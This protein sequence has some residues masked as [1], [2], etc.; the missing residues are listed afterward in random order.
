MNQSLHALGGT[1]A[2]IVRDCTDTSPD[3]A[4]GEKEPWL[5]RKTR[6]LASLENKPLSSLLVTAADK[7]HNAGDMVMDAREDP[8]M[9]S[10]FNAGLEGSAWYLLR[11]HQELVDRL[12]E[13]RSVQKLE[14]A[15]QDIL[16]RAPSELRTAPTPT[17]E[18]PPFAE[19][20]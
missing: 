11:M 14:E 16:S 8:V 5:L 3:A 19:S 10:K 17:L 7:A 20:L 4:V 1:V 6:Y 13:S 12:P 2:D 9:R 18:R 15:V